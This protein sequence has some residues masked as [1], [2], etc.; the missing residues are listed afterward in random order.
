MIVVAIIGIL[1]AI[2]VPNFVK[3]SC[4]S[5]QSEAKLGLKTLLLA[6]ETYRASNDTY[7]HGDPATAMLSRLLVGRVQ[8]YR[9]SVPLASSPHLFTGSATVISAYEPELRDDMWQTTQMGGL[10][11]QVPGCR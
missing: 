8:R 2:A 4:R 5:K 10:T 1:A 7:L 9:Y 6:E 11:N 3:F